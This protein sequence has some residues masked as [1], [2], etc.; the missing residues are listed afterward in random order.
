VGRSIESECLWFGIEELDLLT[1]LLNFQVQIPT[2]NRSNSAIKVGFS[3]P[4]QGKTSESYL[5]PTT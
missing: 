3:S 2:L 4:L 5:F 1:E